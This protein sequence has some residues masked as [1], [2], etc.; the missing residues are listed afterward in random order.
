MAK[1]T[2][3]I[4]KMTTLGTALSDIYSR[5]DP[6]YPAL[7]I[8][9]SETQYYPLYPVRLTD[10]TRRDGNWIKHR[11]YSLLALELILEGEV[12]Y[13]SGKMQS[14]ATAGTLFVIVPHSNVRIV[15]NKVGMPRRKLAL[16]ISG[17]AAGLLCEMLGFEEDQLIQLKDPAR[18]ENLMRRIGEHMRNPDTLR[19]ASVLCYDLLTLLS[20]ENKYSGP[21][22]PQDMQQ[23]RNFLQQHFSEEITL[24]DIA[25]RTGISKETLRRRFH[26]YFST[27]PAEYINML[28]MEHAQHLLRKTRLPI[29]EISFR[30][31]FGS[32]LYFAS[33]FRKRFGCNPSGYRHP[34]TE[35]C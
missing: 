31:G 19:E 7:K 13:S 22:I 12:K 2:K 6:I 34:K 10:V 26:H 17:N 35:K 29:K 11:N 25:L 4:E 20:S 8:A 33:A 16:L 18:I 32:P 9:V 15:N 24:A 3:Y 5:R 23:L 30:C 27:T 1:S 14:V 28:R 21:D